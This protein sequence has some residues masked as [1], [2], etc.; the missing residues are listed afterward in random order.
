M[1]VST[2]I[3]ASFQTLSKLCRDISSLSE[4]M[5]LLSW[6]E[7][8][9]M[10]SGAVDARGNQKA[11]LTAIVHDKSTSAELLTAIQQAQR[12]H[13]SL[14]AFQKAVVRDADRN[15]KR[16]VG[17]PAALEQTIAQHESHCVQVWVSARRDDDFPAFLPSLSKMLELMQ[18]KAAL[19]SGE[20][21]KYD[22]MIDMFER[23]LTAD[24]ISEIFSGIA[25]PL[26]DILRR[27]L[28]AKAKCT[29]QV[30]DALRGG[31]DWTTEA[32]E[33][34]CRDICKAL[35]FDFTQG[36]MDTSVH[37]FTGGGGPHDVRITTRYSTYLPF[38][39]IM[40]VVHETGHAMYE[41]GRNAQYEGLAVSEPLSMGVHESQSLFWERMIGQ[42]V[43][44]WRAMLP[45]IHE[46]LPH[47]RAVGA[48]DLF[49]ALNQV[50]T[51]LIRVDA[52][53]VTYPFHIMLRFELERKLVGGQLKVED[54]PNAWQEG[55]K[56]YL[57]MDVPSDKQGCLQDIHWSSGA[58]GYFPSYSLGAM[59]A[60]QLFQH[61]KMV[62]MPDIE[63]RIGRGEFD[64]IREWL[65][66]EIH[67]RGSLYP[68]L[69]ELLEKVTGEPLNPKYFLEYLDDKYS[70]VYA[71]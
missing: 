70:R 53:E 41:Q 65:K 38:E 71:M 25:Q 22:C 23:G 2:D 45:K 39:G 61:L 24:R 44:F 48:E 52:D 1:A 11:A 9:L 20:T 64:G 34:L 56:Q 47:T 59:M 67:E 43:E 15:Y 63:E 55:M 3:P 16:A 54:L 46:V 21:D 4:I 12:D 50:Q 5:G 8:V 36:R 18:R 6:D 57:G 58:F 30:H 7:Q 13:D 17:I 19:M 33:R 14:N 28:A 26:K 37:P 29:R 40:G 62:V 69:D 31:D 35:G 10:P 66:R 27:T 32:Q 49:F 51:S 68:S 60:A 42:N